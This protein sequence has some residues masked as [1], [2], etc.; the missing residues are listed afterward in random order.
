MI[1]NPINCKWRH[2]KYQGGLNSR[3][4][5]LKIMNNVNFIFT[6]YLFILHSFM[7]HIMVHMPRKSHSI[8]TAYLRVID[9]VLVIIRI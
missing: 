4:V 1:L 7:P 8:V 3:N 9:L 2:E 6:T 5:F